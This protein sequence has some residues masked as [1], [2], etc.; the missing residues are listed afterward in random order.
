MKIMKKSIFNKLALM[1]CSSVVLL[2]SSCF[3]T[4]CEEDLQP[5]DEPDGLGRVYFLYGNGEID[6]TSSDSLVNYSFI[7]HNNVAK[8]TIWLRV[9]TA[10]F[11]S[12]VDRYVELEQVMTGKS[13]AVA[14]KHF[15]SFDDAAY[16][17]L[18]KIP[19]DSLRCNI[20]V[21]VLNDAS[22]QN[23]DVTLKVKLKATSSLL[24][25]YE[26]FLTKRITISAVLSKPVN[27]NMLCDW[28][29]GEYGKVKHQFMIDTSGD[30]WDDD[31]LLNV[32]HVNDYSYQDFLRYKA[33]QFSKA[34]SALNAD[35]AAQGLSP[36]A[37]ADG[38][39][40]TFPF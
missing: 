36:L 13:D 32:A 3:L 17:Q 16:K 20:P 31:Y 39:Q 6:K 11:L 34:L 26:D 2:L 18:L 8:D 9:C 10:G 40:V 1:G 28:Y 12:S 35:R 33:T 5:Y 38:T 37:E 30:P 15:V 14:G 29:L 22:L 7:Y 27:W 24:L 21:I 19:G 4:S 25:G 23:G